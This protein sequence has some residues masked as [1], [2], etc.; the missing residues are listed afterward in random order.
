MGRKAI[1]FSS[2]T[3]CHPPKG[4]I[5]WWEDEIAPNKGSA[6][7]AQKREVMMEVE[8]SQPTVAESLDS[9]EVVSRTIFAEASGETEEGMVAVA[10]VIWNRSQGDI[11]RFSEVCLKRDQFSCWNAKTPSAGTGEAWDFCTTLS[12]VMTAGRFV[13]TGTWDHYYNPEKCDPSWAYI[14]GDRSK[15]LLPYDE[16]G[17][18]H[19]LTLGKW[20][21]K[22]AA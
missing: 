5:N 17:N 3:D 7:Q 13:P 19:F 14:D 8:A 10:S 22:S 15:P 4:W 11:G 6:R 21:G 9:E 2:K 20:L 12:Q 18:H 1:R 16:I